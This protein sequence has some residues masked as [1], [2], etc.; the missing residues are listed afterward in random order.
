MQRNILFQKSKILFIIICQIILSTNIISASAF[1]PS[2]SDYTGHKG[3]TIYVSKLGDN[4]DGSSLEKAFHEI[5]TALQSV[6][7]DKACD[8]YSGMKVVLAALKATGGDTAPDIL[9]KALLNVKLNLPPGPFRFSE[10]RVGM[11][12]LR[13]SEVQRVGGKLQ[14][15]PVKE[16]PGRPPY[17]KTYP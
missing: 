14:W 16:Y 17:V 1:D 4:S 2:T 12:P 5:Q 10:G 8:A 7:D 11:V 3:V 9:K 6:P 13:V 15:V